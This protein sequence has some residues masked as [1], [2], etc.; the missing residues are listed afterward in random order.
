M[1]VEL[2]AQNGRRCPVYI[3][4]V[5]AKRDYTQADFSKAVKLH[6]D[7]LPK[8]T[9]LYNTLNETEVGVAGGY[10]KESSNAL[11]IYCYSMARVGLQFDDSIANNPSAE[12]VQEWTLNR[13]RSCNTLSPEQAAYCLSHTMPEIMEYCSQTIANAE[14][15]GLRAANTQCI[16]TGEKEYTLTLP[17]GT[18]WSK[19]KGALEFDTIGECVT[20]ASGSWGSGRNVFLTLSAKDVATGLVYNSAQ[21]GIVQNTYTLKLKTGAPVFSVSSFKI[22]GRTADIT[23]A[24]DGTNTISL[25]LA[26]DWSWTQKPDI[27]YTGTSYAFLDENGKEVAAGADGKID[28]SKAKTLHLTLDL[29]AY[30]ASGVSA[31]T[32]KFTKDYALNIT[33]GNPMLVSF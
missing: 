27:A 31:D 9:S 18:D 1:R 28:F 26:K 8:I 7:L 20:S 19:I 15:R 22:G 11:S 3:V 6:Y 10:H 17:A 5:P 24:A 12:W 25:H 30:A 2:A 32:M 29:S 21:N 33:Q 4:A 23:E 16:S 14:L 13:L